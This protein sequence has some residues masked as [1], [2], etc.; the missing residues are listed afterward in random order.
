VSSTARGEPQSLAGPVWRAGGWGQ[1]NQPP[2]AGAGAAGGPAAGFR[3]LSGGPQ[4]RGGTGFEGWPYWGS[5]NGPA[6]A[7]RVALFGNLGGGGGGNATGG[8]P[9]EP[10]QILLGCISGGSTSGV[11]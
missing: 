10:C 4:S 9:R 7:R 5:Q 1:T 3:S 11:A 8:R 6:C 2:K